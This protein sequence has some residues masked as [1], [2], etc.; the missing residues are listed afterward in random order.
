MQLLYS[1]NVYYNMYYVT[2]FKKK[3]VWR[4]KILK[5]YLRLSIFGAS[6][7]V[8]VCVCVNVNRV[9]FF[10]HSFKW[11]TEAEGVDKPIGKTCI[12][13]HRNGTIRYFNFTVAIFKLMYCSKKSM[14]I[15]L[16]ITSFLR[17]LIFKHV[18]VKFIEFQ[19]KEQ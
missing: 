15:L 9:K 11:L 7:T 16:K 10:I 18:Q 2:F 4:P 12:I 6:I 14:H 8:F 19:Y 3:T 17:D 13:Y 1:S 5:N